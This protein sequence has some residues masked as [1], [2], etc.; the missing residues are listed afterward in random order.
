M[1]FFCMQTLSCSYD[2]LVGGSEDSYTIRW[3]KRH[4]KIWC[5]H[6]HGGKVI[7]PYFFEDG[8]SATLFG[9]GNIWFQQDGATAHKARS[10]LLMNLLK[11]IA[12]LGGSKGEDPTRS[13]E[14]IAR[15]F[16]KVTENA[17]K[18]AQICINSGFGY[19]TDITF[20]T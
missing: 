10:T 6:K 13:E 8:A 9:S 15:I 3:R 5:L 14:F 7:G 16:R 17:V 1:C 4:K 2:N 12:D 19:L 11:Q 18:R 20:P